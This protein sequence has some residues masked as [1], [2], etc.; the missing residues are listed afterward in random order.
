[1]KINNRASQGVGAA[2]ILLSVRR[3]A[4]FVYVQIPNLMAC[5]DFPEELEARG[6]RL[7]SHISVQ[8]APSLG[9]LWEPYS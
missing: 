3:A 2:F 4:D 6:T 8:D 5:P 9:T 1:M 7:V